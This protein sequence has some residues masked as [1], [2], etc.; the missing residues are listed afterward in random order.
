MST[1]TLNETPEAAYRLT[2]ERVEEEASAEEEWYSLT[3][4]LWGSST[5]VV[6]SS[7]GTQ[8]PSW[9]YVSGTLSCSVFPTTSLPGSPCL[10]LL[11]GCPSIRA[12]VA[13]G[14]DRA[15]QTV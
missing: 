9:P 7:Q 13:L 11:K 4:A 1:F 10:C 5:S 14:L 12:C 3:T 15:I 8:L 6:S 2:V